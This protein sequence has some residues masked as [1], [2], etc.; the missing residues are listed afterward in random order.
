MSKKS[1]IEL[2]IEAGRVLKDGGKILFEFFGDKAFYKPGIEE[3]SF[4]GIPNKIEPGSPYGGMYNNA[5]S[6]VEIQAITNA[7][8]LKIDW[9]DKQPITATFENYWVCLSKG[10]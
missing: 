7:A 3:D 5:F 4:S 9:I 10:V 1:A 6:P 2:L 8:N